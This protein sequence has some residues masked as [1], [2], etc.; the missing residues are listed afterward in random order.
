VICTVTSSAEP[1]LLNEWVKDGTHINIVG[2]SYLGPVEIDPPLVARARYI[3][4][5]RP[6]ALAQGAE[7]A[8][9]RDAGLIDDSYFVGEIGEVLAGRIPGRENGPQVTI[10]KS[11]GHVVQDLASAAYLNRQA[12][13]GR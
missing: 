5:Y 4:D 6:G 2:S 11:L 8:A 13:S 12:R 3:A 1:V 9:A 10:Y 7:L